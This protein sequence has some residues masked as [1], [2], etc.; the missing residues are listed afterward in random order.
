MRPEKKGLW[1]RLLS[2]EEAELVLGLG[3]SAV[4][5]ELGK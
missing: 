4:E 2:S 1:P 5:P 3:P